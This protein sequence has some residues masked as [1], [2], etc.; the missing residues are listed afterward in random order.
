MPFVEFN[1]EAD[2]VHLLVSHPPTL[3]ISTLIQPIKG[4]TTYPVRRKCT[5]ACVRA[6]M[7]GHLWPPPYF[8]VTC[9]GAPLST[10]TQ[11]I[12]GQTR[13]R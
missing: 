1:E 6:R 8:T 2:H 4:R 9:A 5:R 11:H 7:R 13:P 12:D 3:A 10:I